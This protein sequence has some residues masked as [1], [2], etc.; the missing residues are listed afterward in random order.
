MFYNFK[1]TKKG[2]KF[3]D[4]TLHRNNKAGILSITKEQLGDI[5]KEAIVNIDKVKEAL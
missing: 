1:L 3:I 4:K 2:L 5:N